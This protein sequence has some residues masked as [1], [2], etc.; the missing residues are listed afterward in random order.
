MF[1]EVFSA[2][3]FAQMRKVPI[4]MLRMIYRVNLCARDIYLIIENEL[5]ILCLY[6]FFIKWMVK[7]WIVRL[8]CSNVGFGLKTEIID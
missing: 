7:M 8:F 6:L 1:Y 5:E 4:G 2:V 3:R